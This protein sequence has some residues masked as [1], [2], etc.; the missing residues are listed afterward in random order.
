MWA[1]TAE[2]LFFH[3]GSCRPVRCCP[4]YANPKTVLNNGGECGQLYV[5]CCVE[6]KDFCPIVQVKFMTQCRRK[7]VDAAM[8]LWKDG[9]R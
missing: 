9:K 2:K 4:E 6:G 3:S 1:D 5:A 8:Q 7:G